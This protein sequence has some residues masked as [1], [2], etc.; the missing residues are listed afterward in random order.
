MVEAVF[1]AEHVRE[2]VSCFS[3]ENLTLVAG[4]VADRAG[5]F[6]GARVTAPPRPHSSR[7]FDLACK[8]L[9]AIDKTPNK[10]AFP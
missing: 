10:V 5:I 2:S 9:N 7:A 3:P 6:P 4:R 1:G 8:A